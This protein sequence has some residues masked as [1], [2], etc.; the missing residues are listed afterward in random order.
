MLQ[1]RNFAAKLL[2]FG[3]IVRGV[4]HRYPLPRQIR[5]A[6]Q[7]KA[8][9]LRV[10]AHGNLVEKHQLRRVDQP[11]GKVQ[12]AFQPARKMLGGFVRV[13]LQARLFY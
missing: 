2:N 3:Q 9:R 4:H 1:Q 13:F 7:N 10:D 5:H 12:T 6:V 11:D 8:A